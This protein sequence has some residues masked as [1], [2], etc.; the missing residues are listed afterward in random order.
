LGA[1]EHYRTDI[2]RLRQAAVRASRAHEA[3]C[4]PRAAS[5][6]RRAPADYPGR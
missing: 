3:A 5:Q 1:H 6:S 4:H 2:V